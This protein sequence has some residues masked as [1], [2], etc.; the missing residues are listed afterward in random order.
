MSDK[1]FAITTD[2]T[3]DLG[4]ARTK[5]EGIPCLPLFYIIDDVE[6][7]DSM[8]D[9]LTQKLYDAMREGKNVFTSQ[10]T[11]EQFIE[12]WTPYM[13]DK[14]DILHIAF[15]SALSGTINS[16]RIAASMLLEKYP[17]RKITVI[18]SLAA[19][20]GEGLLVRHLLDVYKQGGTY[21]ECIDYVES[22]KLHVHHW[23]TV[24]DLVYLKRGGR[25]SSVAAFLGTLLNIKP[26][27]NVDYMGRLIPREKT[28]GRKAA[29]KRMFEHMCETI[30]A[31]PS[32]NA[33]VHIVHG[34]CIDDALYLKNLIL[35]KFDFI[36]EV[37]IQYVGAVIGSHS[38]PGTLAVF[39]LGDKRV[40]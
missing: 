28:K 8:I 17:D 5:E 16:A 40:D 34:D 23:F 11:V 26:V 32:K 18:D 31:D 24:D 14:R 25:V 19:S 36:K 6:Y 29:I 2:T 9:E 20:G 35:N 10:A 38:G 4:H 7:T 33:Y 15:S 39:Y 12:F 37:D 27:L 3:T 30:D 1:L 13:D 21:Q 22:I